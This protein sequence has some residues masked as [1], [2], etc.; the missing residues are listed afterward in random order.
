MQLKALTFPNQ[1]SITIL[2]PSLSINRYCHIK[3]QEGLLI[4]SITHLPQKKIKFTSH[5]SFRLS[6][7]EHWFLLWYANF[8]RRRSRANTDEER[9]ILQYKMP[10]THGWMQQAQSGKL[11]IAERE[12]WFVEAIIFLVEREKRTQMEAGKITIK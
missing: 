2:E 9:K 7:W 8:E 11:P 5:Y 10:R 4:I 3:G 6:F 12:G 1:Q